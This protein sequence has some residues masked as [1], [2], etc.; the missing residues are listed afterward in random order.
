MAVTHGSIK[1]GS[2]T[3]HCATQL[4]RFRRRCAALPRGQILLWKFYANDEGS[5]CPKGLIKAAIK[6][7]AMFRPGSEFASEK[8]CE[9]GGY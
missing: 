9:N 5:W 7:R 4:E 3:L 8:F 6:A 2:Q 1:K